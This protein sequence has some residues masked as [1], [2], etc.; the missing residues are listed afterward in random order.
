MQ[1]TRNRL[2]LSAANSAKYLQTVS[3]MGCISIDAL[4]PVVRSYVLC[5][6]LLDESEA[7]GMNY[8]QLAELSVAKS[9][10]INP[11]LVEMY[12]VSMSCSSI[13]SVAA[14][15]VLLLHSIEKG[16]QIKL[17]APKTVQIVTLRDLTE[18]IY[19]A[20]KRSER[21]SDKLG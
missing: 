20:M 12:D 7:E 4:E 14:K 15:K 8:L 19:D 21:W 3:E 1:E 13:S 6:F 17:D 18:L 9:A 2:R 16:L 5:K 11:E 10:H